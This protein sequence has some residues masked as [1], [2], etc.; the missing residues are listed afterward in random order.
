MEYNYNYTYPTPDKTYI[1]LL[2]AYDK[3]GDEGA[4]FGDTSKIAFGTQFTCVDVFVH[5]RD[6]GYYQKL[7]HRRNRKDIWKIT[8]KGKQ[9]LRFAMQFN[10]VCE[11]INFAMKCKTLPEFKM[12]AVLEAHGNYTTKEFYEKNIKPLAE[13]KTPEDLEAKLWPGVFVD[14][15][16]VAKHVYNKFRKIPWVKDFVKSMNPD[17]IVSNPTE[18]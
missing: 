3:F 15:S 16:R 17:A 9:L 2:K 11:F 18:N 14:K 7:E 1:K 6:Q 13:G 8:E 5:M 12:Q 10:D 4:W